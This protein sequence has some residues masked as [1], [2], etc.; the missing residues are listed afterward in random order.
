MTD[1]LAIRAAAT[2]DGLFTALAA[3]RPDAVPVVLLHG[4]GGG[5]RLWGGQLRALAARY[6]AIA[7][8]MPGYGGSASLS[9]PRIDDF[10]RALGRFLSGL[11]LDRPV[12]VGHSIG[13]MIVQS[14]LAQGLAPVRG[15][16]LAQTSAAFGGRDPV[17]AQEFVASRLGPLEHGATMALLAA[18]SVAGMVGDDPDPE[19]VALAREVI[20]TTPIDAYRAST[21][22]MLGFD[23]RAA[24][25][26]IGVPTLLVSG[27]RDTNAPAG[28][29]S[30][31]AEKVSG[32]EY[33]CVEGSGH[34]VMLE[35][36]DEFGTI[37]GRFLGRVAPPGPQG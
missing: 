12:L 37:L 4:I 31:M 19:G 23:E 20:G 21:V 3:G 13:G 5:A 30:K 7:W 32:A 28:T 8:N 6:R 33:V 22:A 10:A 34:L 36:P 29:M 25:G 35:R 27:S 9:D 26:R 11:E 14:F 24:L 18:E 15:A 1:T 16:V 2:P 17:W